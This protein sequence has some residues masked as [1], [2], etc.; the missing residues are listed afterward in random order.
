MTTTTKLLIGFI[1]GA[2]LGVLYAP[3][4]GTKTR[5]KIRGLGTTLQDK[6]NDATDALAD[7]IDDLRSGVDDLADRTIEKIE[8][9]Q[10][11]GSENMETPGTF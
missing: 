2:V 8:S 10:F 1:S 11:S 7:K 3:A 4:K 6:W 9:T 5:E